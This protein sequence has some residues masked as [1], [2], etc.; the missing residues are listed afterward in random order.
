M[1]RRRG[2][3][4]AE[5]FEALLEAFPREDGTA[6][7]FD[8]LERE[9]D[10]RISASY[11]N[12][13]VEGDV[14]RPDLESLSVIAR[15]MGF[16]MELWTLNHER[17]EERLRTRS[18][19]RE[20]GSRFGKKL[21]LL[22]EWFPHPEGRPWRGSEIA[23]ASGGRISQP[24]FSSLRKGRF[25]RPGAEQ[26]KAIADVMGFPLELWHAEPE[27]WPR[28]LESRSQAIV[29]SG[30][31]SEDRPI[32]ETLKHI[33]AKVTSPVT[34]EP[35]TDAEIAERSHG[36]LSTEE[37]ANIASGFEEDPGYTK[38]LALSDV[39]NVDADY[40]HAGADGDG[41][42]IDGELLEILT[43]QGGREVLRRWFRL[44]ETHQSMLLNML[45]NMERIESESHSQAT[46]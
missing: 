12:A 23:E 8:E 41:Q 25:R 43:Q 1:T 29:G 27:Q 26:L 44:S 34:G 32:K 19:A 18:E 17:F 21:E 39:F 14:S 37:V 38:I 5:R 6:W 9:S 28:I 3:S 11:C 15:V 24:Y 2:Q 16:N 10:G 7:G 13:L 45:D 40:W 4:Y 31:H 42:I 36:R 22:L 46:V 33:R 35:F 20:Q 30:R